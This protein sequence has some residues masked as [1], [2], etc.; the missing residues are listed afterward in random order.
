MMMLNHVT[1]QCVSICFV[2]CLQIIAHAAAEA[3]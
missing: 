2:L 3:G 1:L